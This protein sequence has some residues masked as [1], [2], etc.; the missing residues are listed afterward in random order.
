[1]LYWNY[2]L[3]GPLAGLPIIVFSNSPSSVF[4]I[5]SVMSLESETIIVLS[6]EIAIDFYKKLN[7]LNFMQ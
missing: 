4:H 5:L 6:G 7:I 1:M 2:T 3:H